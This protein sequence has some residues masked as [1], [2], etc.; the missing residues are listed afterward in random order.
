[1][2]TLNPCVTVPL[3][4]AIFLESAL[5]T[6]VN[7]LLP[8][9]EGGLVCPDESIVP[10]VLLPPGTLSTAHATLVLVVPT[11][12]ATKALKTLPAETV[13]VAGETVTLIGPPE[14]GLL[15]RP[16]P[17]QLARNVSKVSTTTRRGKDATGALNC[18][19]T[20]TSSTYTHQC[21]ALQ[22]C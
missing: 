11:T 9:A 4:P 18:F 1:M 12:V 17:P 14:P 6:A 7:V 20:D 2:L 5:L 22:A 21:S 13:A 10:V 19:T 16:K 8:W 15:L 3:G